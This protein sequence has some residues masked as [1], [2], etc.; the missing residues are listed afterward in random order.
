M[1]AC[2][3][4]YLDRL[5]LFEDGGEVWEDESDIL[6]LAALLRYEKHVG[7]DEGNHVWVHKLRGESWQDTIHHHPLK[8]G[9]MEG[10]GDRE[11]VGE[12]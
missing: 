8:G 5:L 4:V 10:G 1:C 9:E 11:K 3:H 12:L 6:L 2:M 7:E